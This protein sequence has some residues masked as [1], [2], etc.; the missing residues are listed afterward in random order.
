MVSPI[1]SAIYSIK[2]NCTLQ[3]TEMEGSC[4]THY[5]QQHFMQLP[6]ITRCTFLVPR[7]AIA[8]MFLRTIQ[9]DTTHQ[10]QV[11]L[12]TQISSHKTS[13]AADHLL[14]SSCSKEALYLNAA[15]ATFSLTEVVSKYYR[16]TFSSTLPPAL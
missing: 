8:F 7:Q 12:E 2:L 11:F 10:Q 4:Y 15:A 1:V 3:L 13:G 6:A 14:L 9:Q 5:L 16:E